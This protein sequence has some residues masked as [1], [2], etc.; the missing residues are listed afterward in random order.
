MLRGENKAFTIIETVLFVAI[1]SLMILVAMNA[2]GSS[3]SNVQFTDSMRSLQ[4]FIE[5]QNSAA[6]SGVN[7]IFDSSIT[8][9]AAG[10]ECVVL[11][12]VQAIPR[13]LDLQSPFQKYSVCC[14]KSRLGHK[15]W[16]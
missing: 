12:R 15:L 13:H 7:D 3:Q 4:S 11:G 6:T 16:M 14:L 9:G 2:I 1:S 5:T 10:D 8:C